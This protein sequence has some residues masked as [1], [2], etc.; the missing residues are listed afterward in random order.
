MFALS[1]HHFLDAIELITEALRIDPYSPWLNGR[2]AWAYHLSGEREK[3]LAQTEHALE[4]F[5][6]H[7]SANVYGS[8]I[9]AFNGKAERAVEVAENLIRKSPYLDIGSSM[10]A[11]AL[12]QAGR[13]QEARTMLERLQWL[14]RERFV[15]TSFTAAVCVALGDLDDAVAELQAAADARCPWLFQMLADP[16][17]ESVRERP[18]VVRIEKVLERMEAAAERK[19]AHEE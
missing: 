11:Y 17:I 8:M 9:L 2:L 14:S 1:R 12:A 4:L 13:E 6:E 10:C 7:E 16:R 18:E 15:L 3:S 19:T 5:P